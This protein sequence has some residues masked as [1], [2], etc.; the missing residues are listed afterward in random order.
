LSSTTGLSFL[1]GS[2]TGDATLTLEG[3]IANINNALNGL[4][5]SPTGGYNGPA[6]LQVSASVTWA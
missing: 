3:S 2:G 4:V 1:V 6:S 5:F